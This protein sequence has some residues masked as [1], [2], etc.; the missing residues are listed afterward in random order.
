M[1]ILAL[2]IAART[3]HQ[4]LVEKLIFAAADVNLRYEFQQALL[5]K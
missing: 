5:E 2:H 3:G 4:E 1:E